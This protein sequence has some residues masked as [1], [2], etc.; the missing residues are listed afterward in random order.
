MVTAWR[1]QGPCCMPLA[2]YHAWVWTLIE[3]LLGSWGHRGPQSL[4]YCLGV[5]PI[6]SPFA[7]PGHCQDVGSFLPSSFVGTGGL[8]QFCFYCEGKRSASFTFSC[9]LL[10]MAGAAILTSQ[11]GLW[12]GNRQN[13]Q[14]GWQSEVTLFLINLEMECKSH[15]NSTLSCPLLYP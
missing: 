4:G 14:L 10:R 3:P 6:S 12:D 9:L 7:S 2:S 15:E 1:F 13:R 11:G 5:S 8:L